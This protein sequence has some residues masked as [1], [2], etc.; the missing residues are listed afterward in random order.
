MARLFPGLSPGHNADFQFLGHTTY[1]FLFLRFLEALLDF[2][3]GPG[4]FENG[5]S[6]IRNRKPEIAN[7][8]SSLPKYVPGAIETRGSNLPLRVQIWRKDRGLKSALHG[9]AA[10]RAT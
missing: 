4:S 5:K 10:T 7:H 2:G 8:Q 1:L 6:E 9:N 3:F